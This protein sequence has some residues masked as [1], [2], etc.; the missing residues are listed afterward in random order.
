[1]VS[2]IRRRLFW[3]LA[4]AN[5]SGAAVVFACIMWVLPG[6]HSDD[7]GRL[8]LLNGILG[9]VFLLVVVPI[10]V[11][12]GEAWARAGRRWLHDGRAP[13]DREVASVLRAPMQLFLIHLVLWLLAAG[14]FALING[15]VELRLLPRV[16]ITVALGGLTTSAIAYLLAERITRPLARAALA[17]RTVQRPALPGV[18]TRTVLGWLLG[19]GVPL[20]GLVVT[21]IFALVEDTDTADQLAVTMVVLASTGLVVGA[22][23]ALMGA[24]A[25]ADPIAG[26][27]RG[28]QELAAGNLD[29]GV[30]VYDGSVLG[31]LQAGFNDMVEGLR[32]RER[33]RDLFGRQV[34]EEVA[35]QALERGAEMGGA[36]CDVAVLFVDVVGSTELATRQPAGEVVTLLNKFF[37]VVI[38]EAERH[39]GWVNKFQGDAT[40][41]VFGAPIPVAD[42]P[43][44]AL[45]AARQLARRLPAEVP[46]LAAGIG[47]ASGRAVAGNIGD[48]RRFEFT[49]IGDPVNEA[50]RLTELAKSRVPMVLASDDTVRAALY[51]ERG[52]WETAGTAELRGRARPTV[53]ARPRR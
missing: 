1:M 14:L 42:A 36:E 13:T 25:V 3:S 47:V 28:M 12:L 37:T 27:R 23:V 33:I 53:L 22:A 10:G 38:D 51:P 39:G 45:M 52:E 8:L 48:E 35:A 21:G 19:T 11:L 32:E 18:T 9:A 26:L 50:S 5:L 4:V 17:V 41:V 44:S 6:D 20:V 24:R 29:T 16:L 43:G 30:V 7:A 15:L 2:G 40:L 34:G 49:V 31:V 46:D